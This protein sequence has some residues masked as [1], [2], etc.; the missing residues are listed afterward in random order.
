M[1]DTHTAYL[2]IGG[3]IGDRLGNLKKAAKYIV[4]ECGQIITMSSIYQTAAWGLTEQPDFL[5]QVIVL[6]TLLQPDILMKTLLSIEEKMG[7]IRTVKLGPRTID[8][9]ILLIDDLVIKSELLTIPHP[10]LPKRKFALIP[11]DEVAGNFYHPIERKTIQQLLI[12]C[13]DELVVQKFSATTI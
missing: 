1:I 12:E 9:D 11:L 8:L 4:Q 2:L 13:N 5:N 10:A 6:S 3:N 7:R